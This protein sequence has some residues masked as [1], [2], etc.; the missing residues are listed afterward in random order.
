MNSITTYL[1]SIVSSV[2]AANCVTSPIRHSQRACHNSGPY[3][4]GIFPWQVFN[5]HV[6][7]Q[8][9]NATSQLAWAEDNSLSMP[10]NKGVPAV[11]GGA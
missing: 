5:Y 11:D 2:A 8:K 9:N 10:P 7:N 1:C 4:P 3:S 6:Q